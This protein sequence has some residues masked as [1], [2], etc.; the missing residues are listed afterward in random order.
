M[1]GFEN[2]WFEEFK[3]T[4]IFVHTFHSSIREYKSPRKRLFKGALVFTLMSPWRHPLWS[5]A[6]K[7]EVEV[8]ELRWRPRRW[9]SLGWRLGGDFHGAVQV[10]KMRCL[11]D[12]E[13]FHGIL[14]DFSG[15]SWDFWDVEEWTFGL[16]GMW[17]VKTNS[18]T[19][20]RAGAALQK[21]L[22][23]GAFF[24]FHNRRL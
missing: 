7:P 15:C 19:R 11:S 2:G 23:V 14:M 10:M 21:P 16:Y 5:S 20:P 8:L 17:T 18:C 9:D 6:P 12:F 4:P 22:W 1:N 3:A 24:F 13:L